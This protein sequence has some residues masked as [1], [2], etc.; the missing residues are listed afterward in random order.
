MASSLAIAFVI[1]PIAPDSEIGHPG[2]VGEHTVYDAGN[3]GFFGVD[4]HAPAD[5]Y[6]SVTHPTV[7]WAPGRRHATRS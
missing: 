2:L 3:D 4:G 1:S 7:A 6:H 5:D